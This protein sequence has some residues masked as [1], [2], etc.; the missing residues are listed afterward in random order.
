MGTEIMKTLEEY[1]RKMGLKV[2]VL[3]VF[4]NNQQVINLYKIMGFTEARRVP[5]RFFKDN[6]Y[7]DKIVMTKVLE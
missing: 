3:S 5:K 4:A 6:N 2:L 1:T 7:I